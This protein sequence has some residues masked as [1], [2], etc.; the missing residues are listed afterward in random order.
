MS[1]VCHITDHHWVFS[2]GEEQM[3]LVEGHY[4]A[5]CGINMEDAPEIHADIEADEILDESP[6]Q[7]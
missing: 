6:Q 5:V 7:P 3:G 1:R 4:C 2:E